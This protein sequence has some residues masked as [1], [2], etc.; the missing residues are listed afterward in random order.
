MTNFRN[1]VA[2][3]LFLT[4]TT[5]VNNAVAADSVFYAG[6]KLGQANYEYT[7]VSN[8][9][10]SAF[11]F[12]V[13]FPINATVAIEAE[14]MSLGGFDSSTGNIKGKSVGVSGVGFF[15][16]SQQF[17]LLVKLGVASTSLKDTAKPGWT[18]SATHNN[19]G[20]TVGFGGQYN[21]SP[22]VGIRVGYDVYPVGDAAST[23][24]STGMMYIGGVFK[25]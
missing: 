11:G 21:V 7:N 25:F 9:N 6:V 12:L 19:T 10:Q 1:V 14:Y 20:F 24:S 16:V 18:G 22:A 15:P 3:F 4:M 13:G 23:T 17:L 5:S 8:N 2:T